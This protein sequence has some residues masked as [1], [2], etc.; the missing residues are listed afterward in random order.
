MTR[1]ADDL[2]SAWARLF[3]ASLAQCGVAHAVISPGSRS[4]PLALAL[5]AQLPS[6]VLHDE[7]VAAFFALGQARASGRVS[8]VLATSGSAPGHWLPAVMEAREA[9]LPLLLLSAD[10]PWEVQQAQAAQTVDQQRLFG[11]HANAYFELGVPDDHPAALRAV[12]RLAAQA[13][14][15]TRYPL[16]GAVQVN[17]HFRKPLEPQPSD[18]QEPWRPRLEALARAGAPRLFAPQAAPHPDAVA[19]IVARV[20]AAPRGV[21]VAGP[22]P[23]VQAAE[24]RAAVLRFVAASGYVLLAEATSQLRFGLPAQT[25]S[26]V[27]GAFDAL[28]RSPVLRQRLRPDLA[29][30]IGAPAVSAQWLAWTDSEQAPAR[31]VLPGERPADPAGGALGMWL[32]PVAALLE[33]AAAQLEALPEAGA[34]GRAAATAYALDWQSA[35]AAAWRARQRANAVADDAPLQ[36]HDIAAVLRAALPAGAVLA[37]GNSSPVRDLDH[38]LPPDGVPLG[39]LHQRGAAGIDGGVAGAAGA[40]SVLEP[41]MALL[42]GDVAL[43]H[44]AGGLAAA[45]AVRGPLALVVVNNDGGRIFERLPLGGDDALAA[46]R[47][48]LFVAPH[49]RSF[50]GLAA[51]WGLGYAR[52]A[53]AQALGRALAQA[54]A[55]DRAVLIEARV[56]PGGSARRATLLAAMAEAAEQ[57]LAP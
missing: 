51:T 47:E 31:L 3:A 30:E 17:A 7:R 18:G 33:A 44:D 25:Q 22:L 39:V 57:A 4:T 2:H 12:P 15:A 24:L 29:L 26:Q 9:G 8:V 19:E 56:A 43:L 13:V 10:R 50:D 42:L 36:E 38:D 37:I 45:A 55:A 35:E 20:R 5:A 49:G 54:L 41:P 1:T 52:V 34:A 32:G 11:H 14:L 16:A 40:R 27:V 28:L 21:L 53:T 6:T 48:R 23:A 46:A